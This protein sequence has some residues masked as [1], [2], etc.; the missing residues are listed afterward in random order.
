VARIGEDRRM[1]DSDFGDFDFG[2]NE[3]AEWQAA[4]EA[5]AAEMRVPTQWWVNAKGGSRSAAR[6][7][8]KRSRP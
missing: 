1:Y 4:L 8:A 3:Y 6:S 7:G 5:E 2:Q